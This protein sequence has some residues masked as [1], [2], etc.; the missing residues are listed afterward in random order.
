MVKS[1]Q[2]IHRMGFGCW[3]LG[4]ANFV[5]GHHFGWGS[6]DENEAVKA[7]ERAL[8]AGINF[9]DTADGYGAGRSE[10]LLGKVL[11]HFPNVSVNVCTKCGNR[12]TKDG[13][14][15]QDFSA[16]WIRQAVQAS[17]DRLQRNHI[18]YLLLHSPPDNF[19]WHDYD[20]SELDRLVMEGKVGRYGVS[21]KSVHGL[22]NLLEQGFGS[23]VECLYNVLDRRAGELF[24][25]AK[26]SGYVTIARVPLASG[27]LSKRMLYSD[28]I[29]SEDDYRSYMK[30]DEFSWRMNAVRSLS[31]LDK[32]E[33]GI[34]V[35]AMRFCLS[36]PSVSVV[37]P[38][39]RT[40][41]QVDDALRAF[42]LGALSEEQLVDIEKS[43]YPLP[44][45]WL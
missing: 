9:Y 27:F 7:L 43:A 41:Q 40:Q 33:G 4:G 26:D 42:E 22:K 12:V 18:E 35:S 13:A 36:S 15:F 8:L 2:A 21:V 32:F 1:N 11:S 5:D 23:V 25:Q 30:A 45:Q 3:Q 31:F 14:T 10:R 44:V 24:Q 37:I 28:P 34:S 20:S 17:M 29:F 6:Y 39:M 19:S 38:G 16:T